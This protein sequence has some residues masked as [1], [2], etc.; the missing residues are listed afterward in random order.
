MSPFPSDPA[1]ETR[2]APEQL[3]PL[4]E[5]LL[6]KRCLFQYDAAVAVQRLLDAD[7]HGIPQ[8]GCALLGSLLDAI[9]LGDIDPRG[10]VLTLADAPTFAVLDGS[11]A[12]GMVAASRGVELALEKAVA[13]GL[14]LIVIGNSQTLGAPEIYARLLAQKGCIGFCTTSTGTATL[15]A[16]GQTTPLAGNH[17]FAY[18]VPFGTDWPLVF[19]ANCGPIS[20]HQLQLLERYGMKLPEGLCLNAEGAPTTDPAQVR[21]L[22]PRGDGL[23]FGLSLFFSTLA[24]PLAGGKMPLHKRQRAAADDSQHV[25][26]AIHPPHFCDVEKF[27]K[28]LATTFEDMRQKTIDA[29][30]TPFELPGDRA[31]QAYEQSMRDGIPLHRT[32]VD[33]LRNRAE[34][35]KVPVPF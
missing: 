22:P 30:T 32:V 7:L 18:A 16:P 6:T 9:D 4:L 11:R 35:L 33:D 23:G 21:T 12:V 8:Q 13:Q 27:N 10:R 29:G 14:A 25:L 1:Q 26:L 19:D 34:K 24:G 20:L 15:A 28:E 2:I 17:G 5:Q 3:R 31:R